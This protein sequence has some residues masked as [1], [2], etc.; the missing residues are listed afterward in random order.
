MSVNNTGAR[1]NIPTPPS[2]QPGAG[3]SAGTLLVPSNAPNNPSRDNK[4]DPLGNATVLVLHY[5]F[6]VLPGRMTGALTPVASDAQSRTPQL[7]ASAH[8]QD[9]ITANQSTWDSGLWVSAGTAF[10]AGFERIDIVVTHA[11]ARAPSLHAG[12]ARATGAP[13]VRPAMNLREIEAILSD[14]FTLEKSRGLLRHEKNGDGSADELT[15]FLP[16]PNHRFAKVQ[17]LL[18]SALRKLVNPELGDRVLLESLGWEKQSKE[19]LEAACRGIPRTS[20][21]F[22]KEPPSSQEALDL[23]VK[24]RDAY[25]DF[26]LWFEGHLPSASAQKLHASLTSIDYGKTSA[27][28]HLLALSDEYKGEVNDDTRTEMELR[29]DKLR[30]INMLYQTKILAIS[31][32]RTSAYFNQVVTARAALLRKSL[33]VTIQGSSHY[34]GNIA[35]SPGS[36]RLILDDAKKR[37]LVANLKKDKIVQ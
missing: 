4:G 28:S 32:E 6:E 15:I 3:T 13:A 17:S 12:Q 36:R 8:A 30:E 19:R 29:L 25:V 10:A 2:S 31:P 7:M 22:F 27:V 5:M 20:C 16:D 35:G 21:D 26:F 34:S 9:A 11:A 18:T 1:A 23:N 37:Y 14:D 33:L 24:T